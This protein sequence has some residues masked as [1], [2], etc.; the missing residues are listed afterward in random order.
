M[1]AYLQLL[2]SQNI[3]VLLLETRSPKLDI[4]TYLNFR[5]FRHE[6]QTLVLYIIFLL[7]HAFSTHFRPPFLDFLSFTKAKVLHS[8]VSSIMP[9]A[10][11]ASV[12]VSFAF[13]TDGL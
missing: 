7:A 6:T 13:S 4:V 2:Q 9:Y 5:F 3:D 12:R 1:N 11:L 10:C 8:H